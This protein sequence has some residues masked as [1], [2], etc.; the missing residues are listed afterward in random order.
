MSN[1][2]V[3]EE[4]A[5]PN[6]MAAAHAAL[7]KKRAA[8]AIQRL[9]AEQLELIERAKSYGHDLES[10][11]QP[12]VAEIVIPKEVILPQEKEQLKNIPLAPQVTTEPTEEENMSSSEEIEMKELPVLANNDEKK[13]PRKK[14]KT[15]REVK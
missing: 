1:E 13:R 12:K 11:E 9:A 2:Q 3:I 15:K 5:K 7:A 10:M 6:R 4:V 8:A 14:K